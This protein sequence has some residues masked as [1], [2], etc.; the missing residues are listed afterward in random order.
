MSTSKHRFGL[1]VTGMNVLAESVELSDGVAANQP[2]MPTASFVMLWLAKDEAGYRPTA[3]ITEDILCRETRDWCLGGV[4]E[5]LLLDMV[6]E[7]R[8]FS[9]VLAKM[10]PGI[11][12]EVGS[13]ATGE[14]VLITCRDRN[15]PLSITIN[16]MRLSAGPID[17]PQ[18]AWDFPATEV[19]RA[20]TTLAPTSV[21][22]ARRLSKRMAREAGSAVALR[23]MQNVMLTAAPHS[24]CLGVVG[25]HDVVAEVG[26]IMDGLNREIEID[27]ARV[28]ALI[29][30]E[31]QELGIDLEGIVE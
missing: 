25:A 21:D 14:G 5:V 15:A 22:R 18:G 10:A 23:E 28:A 24:V 20:S 31:V 16:D 29:E 2:V 17:P 19:I 3:R 26:E 12:L 4:W 6:S 9:R 11:H 30:K 27:E 8:N 1:N 13:T 7:A